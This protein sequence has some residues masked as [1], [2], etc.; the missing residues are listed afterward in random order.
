MESPP[1]HH[2][3]PPGADP[4]GADPIGAKAI[5]VDPIEIPVLGY[6]AYVGILRTLGTGDDGFCPATPT[7]LARALNSWT[8]SLTDLGLP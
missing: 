6:H 4:P 5:E 8:G 1:H 7:G 3:D 2:A